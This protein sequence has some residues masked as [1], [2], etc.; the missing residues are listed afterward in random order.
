MINQPIIC[1]FFKDFIINRKKS[2][3]VFFSRTPLTNIPVKQ[4]RQVRLS[5]NLDIKILSS[6]Y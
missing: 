4:G 1:M 5:N 3:R 2:N 6:T